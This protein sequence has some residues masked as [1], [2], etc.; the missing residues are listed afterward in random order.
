MCS[1]YYFY[2]ELFCIFIF[3]ISFEIFKTGLD[4][5]IERD[6]WLELIAMCLVTSVPNAMLE[7]TRLM[8]AL[9]LIK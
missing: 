4:Q 9:S 1:L 2:Y 3:I 8:A 7:A 6:D 5:V